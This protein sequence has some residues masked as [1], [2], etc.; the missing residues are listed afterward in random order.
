[1][2]SATALNEGELHFRQFLEK[3]PAGAYTCDA[4][5]LITYYNQQ[6]V[7]LWGR[8][9]KLRDAEDRFCGSFRL[10]LSDGSP[11]SHDACWMALALK[12]EREYNGYEAVIERPNGERV[13]ILAQANPI[14]DESGKVCGAL[15]V[16]VDIS[17]RKRAED[18][19]READ[20]RK[21]EFLAMLAHELRNPLAA[22]RNALEV[23]KLAEGD[24]G[25]VEWAKGV[26]DRQSSHLARLVDDL[27]DVS[28]LTLG[29]VRLERRNLNAAL[30]LDRAVEEVRSLISER[31]H[32][33]TTAYEGDL[34][35]YADPARLEQIVAN[36]LTNAAKYTPTGG[37]IWLNALRVDTEVKI[38]VKDTGI[39]ISRTKLPAMFE[40][41]VQGERSLDRNEGGLGLGLTI[42]RNLTEMHG[43]TV[44]AQSDGIGKGSKFTVSLPAVD[45][46]LAAVLERL[47]VAD[48]SSNQSLR[49]LIVDDNR[50]TADGMA[51][52]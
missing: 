38:S 32:E 23:T 31:K 2:I 27:L 41:F 5:G 17:E 18:L 3:L 50:E 39:G 33:L 21:S 8:T 26:V 49:I 4:E 37:R 45:S 29:K 19:L 20:R 12:E 40:L 44:V 6:A 7:N 22:I 51:R 15:N 43:G 30:I 13:T 28:R 36:L 16:M 34:T 24:E 14:R 48:R 25:D 42:V 10:F 52:L 47:K 35:V 11:L 9:P 46:A 1:M